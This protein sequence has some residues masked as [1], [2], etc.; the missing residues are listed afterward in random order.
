MTR[1]I[2]FFEDQMSKVRVSPKEF[3]DKEVDMDLDDPI[4]APKAPL[5]QEERDMQLFYF[6]KFSF[7][8]IASQV[9]LGFL[10]G[11][12]PRGKSM[13]FERILFRAARVTS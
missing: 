6:S 3:L 1:K 7:P 5:Q 2:C 4:D 13:V 12:V 9:K 8:Q 10:S 11:L